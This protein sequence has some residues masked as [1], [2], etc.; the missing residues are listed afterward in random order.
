MIN[1]TI[2]EIPSFLERRPDEMDKLIWKKAYATFIIESK[3]S[4]EEFANKSLQLTEL[5]PIL[6]ILDRKWEMVEPEMMVTTHVMVHRM[7]MT[8]NRYREKPKQVYETIFEIQDQKDHSGDVDQTLNRSRTDSVNSDD[9]PIKKESSELGLK[10]APSV[11]GN[12]DEEG[13]GEEKDEYPW[14]QAANNKQT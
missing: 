13:K 3:K 14:E 7:R 8:L 1:T 12:Q 9:V 2:N 5:L 10:N 4:P 6:R 11:N